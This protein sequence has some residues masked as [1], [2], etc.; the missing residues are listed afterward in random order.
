MTL[1]QCY[2]GVDVSKNWI[3]VFVAS[4]Q[5]LTRIANR[6]S[7]IAAGVRRQAGG[8]A[9]PGRNRPGPGGH[10]HRG[11][12]RSGSPPGSARRCPGWS[13]TVSGSRPT[14][15]SVN[16]IVASGR[17]ALGKSRL[18]VGGLETVGH[19]DGAGMATYYS[20]DF[21]DMLFTVGL[22]YGAG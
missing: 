12:P 21:E 18:P 9:G 8:P 16:A 6:Q 7:S 15:P 19:H 1:A 17:S 14:Y 4:T 2:I 11:P 5:K 20:D 13:A 3:D 10:R 22:E